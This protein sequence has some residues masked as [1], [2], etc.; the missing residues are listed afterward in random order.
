MNQHKE[1]RQETITIIGSGQIAAALAGALAL[2]NRRLIKRGV[3]PLKISIL[4]RKN[5]ESVAAMKLR[6]ITLHYMW[7]GR[8]KTSV[9]KSSKFCIAGDANEILR[10]NGAQDHIFVVT[11]A[12]D[13]DEKLLE[14]IKLLQRPSG[15]DPVTTVILAQNGVPCWFMK[16]SKHS[17][18]VLDSIRN[19][20]GLLEAIKDCSMVGC[21]LNLA[22]NVRTD[23]SNDK[24]IHGVYD[25]ATPFEKIAI[26]T[27]SIDGKY[28]E[29]LCNLHEIFMDSGIKVQSAGMDL[30]LEV[31]IKL[32]INTAVN[33]IC[34]IAGKTIGE[35]MDNDSPFRV[36][37]LAA[38]QE[39]NNFSL[40][41]IHKE[42]RSEEELKQ[43]WQNNASHFPSMERD[44]AFGNKMEVDAIY[45]APFE[46][47]EKLQ[48]D[49]MNMMKAIA[50]I[51]D[52]MVE[53]RDK[54]SEATNISDRVK[55]AR[56]FVTPDLERLIHMAKAKYG[57]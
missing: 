3:K 27:D 52:K 37:A 34:A 16:G 51:L 39:I 41:L 13:H 7:G 42:L 8:K 38:A 1:E 14:T 54:K 35:V 11:K 26:P 30:K 24:P 31:L 6:G 15:D 57:S 29:N 10:E 44:F 32:Q 45:R 28:R 46:I 48:L 19:S 36:V 17:E 18:I 43:V 20:A 55:E 33:G 56:K 47:A 2:R 53:F 4:G 12:F 40:S 21:V 50:N 9:I 25:I 5:S 22:V 49:Y 23:P